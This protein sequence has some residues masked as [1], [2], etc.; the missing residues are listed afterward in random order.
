M[1]T[2]LLIL[3][4]VVAG[5]CGDL[6]CAKGM[7]S[8][9]ELTG[10]RP[11]HIGRLL[12]SIITRRMVILGAACDALSFFSL[13]GLLSRAQLSIA[14]P[15]TAFSFVVDTLGAHFFLR[16]HIPWKRWLGVLCVAAGV[17][18]TVESSNG[19]PSARTPTPA[20]TA[21]QTYHH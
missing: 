1:F 13:L 11:S 19:N 7:A 5:S 17:L 21:V 20:P 3:L 12:R 6:F 4:T 16:E 14:V 10:F 8:G 9:G 18:L 2:W 15:A